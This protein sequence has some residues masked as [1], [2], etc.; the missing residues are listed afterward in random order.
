MNEQAV[1]DSLA[2]FARIPETHMADADD[3][4]ELWSSQTADPI[5][6]QPAGEE[7]SLLVEHGRAAQAAGDDF[8]LC[9]GAAEPIIECLR[10]FPLVAP[11]QQSFYRAPF[12]D[13]ATGKAGSEELVITLGDLWNLRAQV[14]FYETGEVLD[15][16]GPEPRQQPVTADQLIDAIA[17]KVV[18]KLQPTLE[19]LV[20]GLLLGDKRGGLL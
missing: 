18:E 3:K 13:Q 14:H 2:V 8:D 4:R 19:G 5:T 20:D 9:L 6:G 7:I 1:I 16:S 15:I 12:V 11:P 17:D 10:A